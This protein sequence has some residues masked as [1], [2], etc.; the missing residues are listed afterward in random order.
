MTHTQIQIATYK[1]L[2]WI[3][4]GEAYDYEEWSHY[5]RVYTCPAMHDMLAHHLGDDNHEQLLALC[6]D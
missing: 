5:M 1:Y 6:E 3:A 4:L 2:L